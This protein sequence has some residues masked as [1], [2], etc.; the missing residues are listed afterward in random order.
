MP[1]I[2]KRTPMTTKEKEEFKLFVRDALLREGIEAYPF[3]TG[4]VL[5]SM[6]QQDKPGKRRRAESHR[7]DLDPEALSRS[8]AGRRVSSEVKSPGVP[9]SHSCRM[10]GRTRGWSCGVELHEKYEATRAPTRTRE[11]NK[12]H[13]PCKLCKNGRAG[14]DVACSKNRSSRARA[15]MPSVVR[16]VLRGGER[17]GAGP[18]RRV[19]PSPRAP[20]PPPPRPRRRSCGATP[21]CLRDRALVLS[22]R[23][24]LV[25]NLQPFLPGQQFV[26]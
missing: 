8:G 4:V 19:R 12:S 15:A 1:I 11:S 17:A 5:R 13:R 24:S 25:R 21:R 9:R 10:M 16:A 2:A 3:D 26:V 6:E 14:E 7:P 23:L 18:E 20:P 22:H